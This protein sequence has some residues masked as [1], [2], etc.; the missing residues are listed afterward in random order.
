[1]TGR[2]PELELFEEFHAALDQFV[3]DNLAADRALNAGA[4]RGYVQQQ[5]KTAR[6]AIGITDEALSGEP[7]PQPEPEPEP[8]PQPA[9]PKPTWLG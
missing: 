9:K 6:D 2:P 8:E 5:A 7:E 1:M 4:M 3:E